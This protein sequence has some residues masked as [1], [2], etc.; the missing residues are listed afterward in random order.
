[1]SVETRLNTFWKRYTNMKT[2][3]ILIIRILFQIKIY[4]VLLTERPFCFVAWWNNSLINLWAK[5]VHSV[6]TK[7]Y[8]YFIYVLAF[9]FELGTYTI[10]YNF[11]EV[12]LD[13]MLT[14]HRIKYMHGVPKQIDSQS[15]FTQELITFLLKY[16][17]KKSSFCIS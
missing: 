8:S 17:N 2:V 3:T 11:I 9:G 6:F 5:Q 7:W 13:N 10:S 4:I 15:I 16:S 1:M 12:S 14:C